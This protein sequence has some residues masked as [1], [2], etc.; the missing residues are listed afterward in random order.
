M[1]RQLV[2]WSRDGSE[3]LP[4]RRGSPTGELIAETGYS[5]WTDA[6]SPQ[7]A[8][9]DNP[10]HHDLWIK[11]VGS[12]WLAMISYWDAGW[13]LVDMDDPANPE[14][15]NDSDYATAD[16]EFPQFSPPEG[17]AHQGSWSSNNKFWVGTDEDFGAFRIDPF[18]ITTGANAGTE[19][20][21]GEFGWTVPISTEYEDSQINGPT[22]YIGT[23]CPA[24][25]DD[26]ATPDVDESAG[27]GTASQIPDASTIEVAEGEERIAVAL[28][29]VC[30][31][32]EKIEQAQLKG[33][34]AVIVANHHAGSGAGENPDAQLCGSQGHDFA[35]TVNAVCVGH[36]AFHMIF[37]QPPTYEGADEPALGSE[38]EDVRA[39]AAFDGWGYAHLLDATTLEEI[40]TYAVA[41]AKDR[42]LVTA[43]GPVLS[44][45][46]VETDK[47][48][49]TNLA[50]FSWC[51]AGA[52]V[53]KFGA[54]GFR[55][56]GHFID[57]GGNDFWGVETIKRG[58]RR[59]L[60]LFSDRDFGL[61]IL[62]YTGP[63]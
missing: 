32:S 8:F 53:T 43:G 48:R 47:R 49:G 36:R 13:V 2:R 45:H 27:T 6:I 51:G 50:Y 28:R 5:E 12:V 59:P 37:N 42:S 1:G 16:P 30:F 39:V 46:E 58:K 31:F 17:N 22:V 9:G 25:A 57:R 23:A 56:T 29:G 7:L 20:P 18:E 19:F 35:P 10:N 44:V 15:V 54:R 63:Q 33:Y 60:L 40:D 41:E 62:K 24:V 3:F 26:P 14:V 61:Y 11:K 34:D 21:A 38:G 55:E 4:T 52:R